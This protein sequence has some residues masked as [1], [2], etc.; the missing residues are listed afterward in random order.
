MPKEIFLLYCGEPSERMEKFYDRA[1]FKKNAGLYDLNWLAIL[2]L[3]AW[4]GYRKQWTVLMTYSLLIGLFPYLEFLLN[5]KLSTT[6]FLGPQIALGLMSTS[7]F[8]H[9]ANLKY[10]QLKETQI[11]EEK[12]LKKMKGQ[13][14][15]SIPKAIYGLVLSVF[16]IFGLSYLAE[17][18]FI[19]F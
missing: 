10:N 8:F 12:I 18:L 6:I 3:P 15:T 4:L 1:K 9:S 17:Y 19:F 14:V 16:I 2:F 11:E 13:G 7:L 5:I